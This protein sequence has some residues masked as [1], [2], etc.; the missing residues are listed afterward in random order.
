MA[1]SIGQ[2]MPFSQDEFVERQRV[3]QDELAR[4]RLDG[5]L[6]FS[7]EN[8]FWLTGFQT[9][10]YFTFQ[11]LLLPRTGQPKLITR[12][13]NG[14]I[15]AVTPTIA[16]TRLWGFD[17]DVATVVA[18]FLDEAM[19][20]KARIGLE[21]ES[22][23]LSVGLYQRLREATQHE[24][25]NWDRRIDRLRIRKSATEAEKVRAAAFAAVKGVDAA[26]R[27]IAPGK[28]END[29]A[30][31]MHDASFRAGGEYV[32]A[33][34]VSSGERTALNFGTW[35]RRQLCKGDVILLE[36][37]ACVD[38]YH[39]MITR[40]CILGKAEPQHLK[41][42][43]AVSATL[44]TATAAIR[45]GASC[46]DVDR[47][48]KERIQ[49]FGFKPYAHGTGYSIGIGFPP[50]WWE[51]DIFDISQNTDALL[52]PNMTFHV[53]PSVH[54]GDFHIMISE[55]VHVTEDSCKVLTPY[56][57]KLFEIAV[58]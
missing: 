40:V 49:D 48:C 51:G 24:L 6:L 45:P 9:V 46:K 29:L 50:R 34:L 23:F 17:E 44:E 26:I 30:A 10:A 11:C 19:R 38:R 20:A 15:A 32:R 41:A 55:S 16:Q 5:V 37:G 1:L 14:H 12:K 25:V 43:E 36:A 39:A 53:C 18:A 35:R 21:V 31:A 52:E 28:T 58:T 2:E 4:E 57:R 27:E 33:P 56:P 13:V 54:V 47:T 42:A 7:P 22:W 3:V 8:I